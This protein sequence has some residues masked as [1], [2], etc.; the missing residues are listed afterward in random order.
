[1]R[2]LSAGGEDSVT[3]AGHRTDSIDRTWLRAGFVFIA[4]L[5]LARITLLALSPVDLYP[6]EAQYWVWS[7][8]LDWGYFSKPPLIAWVISASTSLLGVTDFAIRLPSNVFHAFTG[9]FLLLAGSRLEAPKTGFWA[10]VI[11]LTMP[12][13]WLSAG[14]I[15]TDAILLTFWS[16][17][18]YALIRLRQTGGWASAVGLG[19][20]VGLGFLAKY[21][22]I[23]FV[24]GTGLAIALDPPA[25]RALVSIK[26]LV[27]GLIAVGFLL[28]NMMWNAANDFA[29][30]QHTADNANWDGNYFHF[31]ELADF[32]GAQFIGYGPALFGTLLAG[33]WLALKRPFAMDGNNRLFL[34][35]FSLPILLVVSAQAFISRAHANWAAATYVA[36]SLLVA[37]VL[38]SGRPWRRWMLYASIA[39]SCMVGIV[40]TSV[41]MSPPLAETLGLSNAFKRVRNWE[42]TAMAVAEA[43]NAGDY[44]GVVF[45]D[46]NVFHEMQRYGGGIEPELFM[47]QRF[48]APHNHADQTWPLPLDYA[49]S[50]LVVSHRPLDTHRMREDF[51]TFE[52]AGEIR[53]PVG[54]ERERVFTLWRAQGHQRV[55]RT[56][57]YETRWAEE[58]ARRTA[59]GEN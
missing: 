33:F 17:A 37:I 24:I 51:E 16:G 7:Q 22:I 52:P 34:V 40:F 50:V 55:E 47:W 8:N 19:A 5:T 20:A 6:D 27:A 18:L 2:H 15:S 41:A 56:P 46:R 30:V 57:E 25:R 39:V 48:A 21:A 13:A 31:D 53:I 26:G 11:Y 43:A 28:P 49:G 14:I 58:D 29:T 23:Y 12:G 35:L 3:E 32:L 54:G 44:D 9:L 1:M 36:A 38:M 4:A 42:E 10:A 45:D 59:A